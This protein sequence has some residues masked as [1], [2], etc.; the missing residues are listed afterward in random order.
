M[1]DGEQPH[2]GRS[3][4]VPPQVSVVSYQVSAPENF[5]FKVEEWKIWIRCFESFEKATGFD[6]MSGENQVNTLIYSM[7]DKTNDIFANMAG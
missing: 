7:G 5:T 2:V 3:S 4:Q 6:E 1:A